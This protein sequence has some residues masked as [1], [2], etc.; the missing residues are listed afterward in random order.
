MT[1][2]NHT[3]SSATGGTGD[4]GIPVFWWHPL[5]SPPALRAP[6]TGHW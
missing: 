4:P 1:H 6:V 5:T 2:F 3:G